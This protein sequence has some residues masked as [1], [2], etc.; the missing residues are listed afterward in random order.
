MVVVMICSSD[1]GN[2]IGG[3]E[4]AVAFALEAGLV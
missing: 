1:A 2:V 4:A 3:V